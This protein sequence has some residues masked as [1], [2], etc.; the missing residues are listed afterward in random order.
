MAMLGDKEGEG[1]E[2]EEET[3]S[4]EFRILRINE[5]AKVKPGRKIIKTSFPL[6]IGELRKI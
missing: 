6:L 4:I 1:G 3:Y 2:K 5:K